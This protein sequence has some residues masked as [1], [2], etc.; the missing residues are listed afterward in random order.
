MFTY[1]KAL[2]KI[3]ALSPKFCWASPTFRF[4]CMC[5]DSCVL[6]FL[7][8]FFFHTFQLYGTTSA[9]HALLSIVHAL[10]IHYSQDSQ[11]LYSKK[12]I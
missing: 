8:L 5:L 12:N 1:K 3:F 7:P 9:V 11:P 6:R 2:Y 10:F 4:N